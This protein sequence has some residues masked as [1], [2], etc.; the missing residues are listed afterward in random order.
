M[1]HAVVNETT[2]SNEMM[3]DMF[4]SA[5]SNPE[6]CNEEFVDLIEYTNYNYPSKST[7][8]N[9]RTFLLVTS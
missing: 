7:T 6:D 5:A 3:L 4:P 9:E 8:L 1:A 2:E